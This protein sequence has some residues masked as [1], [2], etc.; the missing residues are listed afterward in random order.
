MASSSRHSKRKKD[1]NESVRSTSKPKLPPIFF[2]VHGEQIYLDEE[3]DLEDSVQIKFHFRT[4][5]ILEKSVS[6]SHMQYVRG[7][8][9]AHP[10]FVL[11]SQTDDHK[12]LLIWAIPRPSLHYSMYIYEDFTEVAGTLAENIMYG[13]LENFSFP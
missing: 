12:N 5:E 1:D 7:V 9:D 8:C 2:P 11:K 4:G 3:I 10:C 6:L 13:E